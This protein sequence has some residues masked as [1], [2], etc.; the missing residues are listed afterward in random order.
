MLEH[1]NILIID[2]SEADFE[3]TRSALERQALLTYAFQWERDFDAA[4]RRVIADPFDVILLDYRL[5]PHDGLGILK[6]ARAAGVRTPFVV[7]TG[8]SSTEIDLAAMRAGA[9]DFIPKDRLDPLLLERSIRYA[10]ERQRLLEQVEHLRLQREQAAELRA[11][12][13]MPA[14]ETATATARIYGMGPLR[15]ADPASFRQA[16]DTY[17]ACLERALEERAFKVERTVSV[18]LRELG[19]H[20]GF[21]GASA[22]DVVDVHTAALRRCTDGVNTR[23]A[24]ATM[25][26]SRLL[27]VELMGHLV[28]YYRLGRGAAPRMGNLP[29]GPSAHTEVDHGR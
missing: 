13:E 8:F 21:L 28:T 16:V 17:A 3:L 19:Q 26:E 22:R 7:L 14:A 1:V 10:V 4:L 6:A 29:P 9:V 2:D 27:L 12:D 25:E 20:L 18:K 23:R 5:G 24:H 15:E 11:L